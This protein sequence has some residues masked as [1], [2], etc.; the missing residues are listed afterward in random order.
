M[1][2]RSYVLHTSFS[3]KYIF[4][5]QDPEIPV[6]LLRN[7]CFFCDSNGIAS[8]AQCFDQSDPEVLPC[9]VAH[10]LITIVA[11]VSFNYNNYCFI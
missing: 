9:M 5:F 7:V 10:T 2:I 8:I 4:L 3:A 1:E 11:N 6:Y